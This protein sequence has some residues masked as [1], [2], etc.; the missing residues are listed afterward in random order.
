MTKGLAYYGGKLAEA[1][2]TRWIAG[3]LPYGRLYAEPFGGM[4]GV[5]LTRRPSNIEIIN[6]L[7]G[8]LA[9]WWKVCR[10]DNAAL[11]ER[12]RWT[13]YCEA[14]FYE[15]RDADWDVMDDVWR[16]WAYTVLLC[17]SFNVAPTSTARFSLPI[18]SF[19]AKHPDAVIDVIVGLRQRLASVRVA[20][21]DACDF[22]ELVFGKDDAVVYCDPPYF[23]AAYDYEKDVLDVDRFAGLLAGAKAR[24]LV[25]G[26]PGEW[27]MLG[28]EFR[29]WDRQVPSSVDKKVVVERVWANYDLDF[30]RLW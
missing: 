14:T 16:A 8:R 28:W 12:L 29:D 2:M 6:D 5:L 22:A 7:D 11:V 24:V 1:P 13:A 19:Q 25:S 20:C 9:N 23:T 17:Q 4:A 18:S 15:I 10:D 26:Y 27:D 3:W 30:G 21:R